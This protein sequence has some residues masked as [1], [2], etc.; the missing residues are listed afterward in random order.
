M[1][2]VGMLCAGLCVVVAMQ[3]NEVIEWRARGVTDYKTA[4]TIVG[5][6]VVLV[7][8]GFYL[9]ID[10]DVLRGKKRNNE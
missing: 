8:C 5:S 7:V 6:V 9:K 2:V 1:I 10:W 3:V 4:L